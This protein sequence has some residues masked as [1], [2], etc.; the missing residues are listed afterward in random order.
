M[1]SADLPRFLSLNDRLVALV[2]A[3]VPVHLGLP[4]KPAAAAALC[5]RLGG[6]ISCRVGEGES[7]D[8]ALADSAV[9]TAYRTVVQLALA[10]GSL[11]AA[12]A[13]ASSVAQERDEAWHAV[14]VAL[15]YPLVIC[16]LAYVGLVLFSLYLVP[17]LERM[18]QSMGLRPGWGLSAVTLLAGTLPFWIALPPLAIVLTIVALRS[19]AA[20]ALAGGGSRLLAWIPGMS[21]VA[22]E[23]ECSRFAET[24]AGYLEAGSPLS[25]ALQNAA[26]AW[27]SNT[28]RQGTLDLAASL[29]RGQMPSDQSP[30]AQRLPPMLRWALWHSDASV[31]RSRALAIAAELYR[32]SAER[33]VAKLRV[34]AP[35]VTC[36]VIGG[37]VTLLYGLALFVPVAQMLQGLAG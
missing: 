9:P 5:E 25:S 35:I 27:E 18:Y 26:S 17:H 20:R 12:L 34:L 8:S 30:F 32:D 31:G 23:Q 15:R 7:L 6:A 2:K 1:S 13:G 36:L 24:L 37:S 3:G 16:G 4:S 22:I 29:A 28:N 10:G 19:A 21:Q 33:R 14:R 11:P